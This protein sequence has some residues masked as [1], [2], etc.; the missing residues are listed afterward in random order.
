MKSKWSGQQLLIWK[1]TLDK[2]YRIIPQAAFTSLRKI[3]GIFIE[4]YFG[5][6]FYLGTKTVGLFGHLDL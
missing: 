3:T 2:Y 4:L 5:I 6:L 1:E